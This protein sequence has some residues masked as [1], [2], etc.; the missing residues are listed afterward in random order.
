MHC[1]F[2]LLT[3]VSSR[4]LTKNNALFSLLSSLDKE[5][6]IVFSLYWPQSPLIPW[7]RTV[8]YFP[9]IPWQRTVHYFLFLLTSVSSPPL[10]KN[11]AL[12]SFSFDL[13]FPLVFW[14]RIGGGCLVIWDF[15]YNQCKFNCKLIKWGIFQFW[16]SY[17]YQ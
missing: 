7:Q 4:L 16:F 14:W 6:C 8:H 13:K 12:F 10:T 5:Q 1:F 17:L 11:N 2:F 15:S 9:L 3:S